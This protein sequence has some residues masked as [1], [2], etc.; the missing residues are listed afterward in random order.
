[1]FIDLNSVLINTLVTLLTAVVPC[2]NF[3]Y[4]LSK[5]TE[6]WLFL[7]YTPGN[8]FFKCYTILHNQQVALLK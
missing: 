6:W 2:Q 4:P 3:L 7:L 8:F 5:S 1:M